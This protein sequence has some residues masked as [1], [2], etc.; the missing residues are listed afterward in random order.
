MAGRFGKCGAGRRE[1]AQRFFLIRLARHIHGVTSEHEVH[2]R[3]FRNGFANGREMRGLRRSA[4]PGAILDERYVVK[5]LNDGGNGD[6]SILDD[7]LADEREFEVRAEPRRTGA[8]RQVGAPARNGLRRGTMFQRVDQHG[9]AIVGQWIDAQRLD[10]SQV[11]GPVRPDG[12]RGAGPFEPG[13]KWQPKFFGASGEQQRRF[14]GPIPL[15]GFNCR[16]VGLCQTSKT[17]APDERVDGRCGRGGRVRCRN[18][19]RA[20]CTR[21]A[22]CKRDKKKREV[23]T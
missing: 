1:A 12:K 23:P 20:N 13:R 5:P 3:E 6:V 22:C 14:K 15:A 11:I 18:R 9:I 16:V 17:A 21:N 10:D 7:V 2:I 4:C 8:A 19:R